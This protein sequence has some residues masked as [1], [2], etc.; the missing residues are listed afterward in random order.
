MPAD[1]NLYPRS[2]RIEIQR[3]YI[4]QHINAAPAKLNQLNRRQPRASATAVNVPANRRHRSNTAQLFKNRRIPHVP[5]MQNMFN[6]AE[7]RN[8]FGPQQ[9]MRIGNDPNPHPAIN[10]PQPGTKGVPS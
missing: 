7:S 3:M 8:S 6:P 4:M 1:H 5:G 2:Q 10:L 9:P